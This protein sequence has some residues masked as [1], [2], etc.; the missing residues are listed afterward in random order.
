[1]YSSD[2]MVLFIKNDLYIKRKNCGKMKYKCDIV[3][4]YIIVIFLFV[5]V[6]VE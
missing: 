2:F 5:Y 1:M 4:F 3:S 6:F